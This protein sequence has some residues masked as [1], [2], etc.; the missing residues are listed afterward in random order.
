MYA[1]S[2]KDGSYRAMSAC[3]LAMGVLGAASDLSNFD[4]A[5][6][7]GS[8]LPEERHKYYMS[9][10]EDKNNNPWRRALE[11]SEA[12]RRELINGNLP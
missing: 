12:A 6:R 5:G 1:E 10:F 7:Q 8:L 11:V 2:N 3:G 4:P 9:L